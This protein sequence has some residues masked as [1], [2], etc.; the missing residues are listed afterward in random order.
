MS[1]DGKKST[2]NTKSVKVKTRSDNTAQNLKKSGDNDLVNASDTQAA[3][4]SI[5]SGSLD[6]ARDSP[7]RSDTPSS[8]ASSSASRK[9]SARIRRSKKIAPHVVDSAADGSVAES[10]LKL[11]DDVSAL[12]R[13]S[14]DDDQNVPVKDRDLDIL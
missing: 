3:C 6:S 13:V 5:E 9:G 14:V 11:S 12:N 10:Q 7:A 1:K 4:A 8:R 2:P